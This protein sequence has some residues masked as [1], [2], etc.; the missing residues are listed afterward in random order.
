[1]TGRDTQQSH[2]FTLWSD[3]KKWLF[4]ERG[5]R[6][7][8]WFF[9]VGLTLSALL[10]RRR[11]LLPEGIPEAGWT[12]F[13]SAGLALGVGALG[14]ALEV[15][16]HLFLFNWLTDLMLV[17]LIGLLAV[18]AGRSDFSPPGS[19]RIPAHPATGRTR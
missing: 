7:L 11:A 15:D 18:T 19:R 4:E 3:C 9:A 10:Y 12:L 16:R 6:Y 5:G 14:D 1:M 17:S 2:H 8:L 13:A